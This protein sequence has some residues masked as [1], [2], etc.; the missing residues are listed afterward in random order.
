MNYL[1]HKQTYI[2]NLV[3]IYGLISSV[4]T[5]W[6]TDTT[7]F[8]FQF[9]TPGGL[10]LIRKLIQRDKKIIFYPIAIYMSFGTPDI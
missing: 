6:N 9:L 10:K 3:G 1:P 4:E 5:E 7:S 8:V 2:Q